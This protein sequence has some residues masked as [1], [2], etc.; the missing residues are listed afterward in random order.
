MAESGAGRRPGVAARVLSGVIRFYQLGISPMR[1]ASCRY[2][3]TCSEYARQALSD[4]G[5]WRGGYY[6]IRRLLR[7]HP[8]HAGGYDPVPEVAVPE[9]GARRSARHAAD[10]KSAEAAAGPALAAGQ[11]PVSALNSVPVAATPHR[12]SP[13]G[14]PIRPTQ[15]AG[16]RL[17]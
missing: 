17:C 2:M 14:Q 5:A 10:S 7:C 3:P 16:E 1:G 8:F 13:P 6:A 12:P 4:H 11:Q 15:E 9:V